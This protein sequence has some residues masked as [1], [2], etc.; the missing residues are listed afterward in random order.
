MPR[1]FILS[2]EHLD[3]I[4][5]NIQTQC[6]N[7]HPNHSLKCKI[8]GWR[9]E[10]CGLMSAV[11]FNPSTMCAFIKT[12]RKNLCTTEC[13]GQIQNRIGVKFSVKWSRTCCALCLVRCC[14]GSFAFLSFYRQFICRLS[15]SMWTNRCGFYLVNSIPTKSIISH[16]LSDFFMS[17]V[18]FMRFGHKRLSNTFEIVW[19]VFH[20]KPLK[21][22]W[23]LFS[24]KLVNLAF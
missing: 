19:C 13:Y 5:H 23:K 2:H 22:I 7:C 4:L 17:Q 12:S 9:G 1:F 24:T 20:R 16:T 18:D 6:I 3:I 21:S 11:T 15:I 10:A 14:V 8:H